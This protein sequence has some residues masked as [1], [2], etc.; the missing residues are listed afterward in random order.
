VACLAIVAV[1]QAC[2]S[3]ADLDVEFR[4]DG[5]ADVD[6]I[7]D[8][9]VAARG[10]VRDSSVE[11]A[12]PLPPAPGGGDSSPCADGGV[13]EDVGCSPTAGLGCCVGRDGARCIEQSTAEQMCAGG[14]FIACRR[15]SLES[16]CCWKE[17]AGG[18]Y[19]RYASTCAAEEIA[20]VDDGDCP[21]TACKRVTCAPSMIDIGRCGVEPKCPLP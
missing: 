13:E 9:S 19:T 3:I 4:R 14:L 7:E 6:V 2:S 16:A 10:P 12:E 1:A 11:R 18:T 17:S 20:C 5:A 21:G 15:R 8:G